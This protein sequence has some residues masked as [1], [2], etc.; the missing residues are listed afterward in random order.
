M[1]S[2][3]PAGV[4]A[5]F[6]A[7]TIGS[8]ASYAADLQVTSAAANS[9]SFGLEVDTSI[10]PDA[11]LEDE[12]PVAET[13]Y[14]A[15]FYLNVVSAG[16]AVEIFRVF[17]GGD[18]V[19]AAIEVTSE[20]HIRVTAWTDDGSTLTGTYAIAAGWNSIEINW[21]ASS[22][23]AA[24]D[25]EVAVGTNGVRQTGISSLD[26]DTHRVEYVRL[27][28]FPLAEPFG[29]M[30]ID[31]FDSRRSLNI[32]PLPAPG[33]RQPDPDLIFADGFESGDIG[34]WSSTGTPVKP[35]T[36]GSIKALYPG[37]D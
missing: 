23:L 17:S 18:V 1:P 15:R 36:W 3:L 21:Q 34:A 11:W 4:L 7:L 12:T 29:Q 26:N 13:I 20:T 24:E 22:G 27:G 8:S 9:G 33:I 19:V 5:I 32:G 31:D 16:G 25:G 6:L 37:T 14:S 35:A 30:A 28:A 2:R 10:F